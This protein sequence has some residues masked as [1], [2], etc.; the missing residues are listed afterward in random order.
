MDVIGQFH[1]PAALFPGK[2]PRINLKG[3]GQGSSDRGKTDVA[4]M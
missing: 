3:V 1:A 2:E 4:G